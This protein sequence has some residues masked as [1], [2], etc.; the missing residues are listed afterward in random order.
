MKRL[1]PILVIFGLLMSSGV[2]TVFAQD[3]PV[4]N[5]G[6]AGSTIFLPVITQAGRDR[7]Q[8]VA[9]TG[10]QPTLEDTASIAVEK[11]VG[12]AARGLSQESLQPVSVIVTFDESVSAEQ[13]AGISGGQIIHRYDKILNGISMIVGEDKVPAV[14][15]MPGVTGVYL[16]ELNALNTDV[17]PAWIGA[18][19]TWAAL[20]GQE[21][22]GEGVIVG[23]IDSGIWPEHPSVS[24]PDPSGK[25]YAAPPAKWTGTGCDF[26]TDEFNPTDAPFTCNNKLIGAY[27]FTGTYAQ[28]IGLLPTEF[29]SARDSNGHGTHTTDHFRRQCRCRS[30]DLRSI[31]RHRLRYRTAR[32]CGRLQGLRR[33]RLLQLGHTWLPST[34]QWPTAS[35]SSTTR[36]AAVA[37]PSAMSSRW[38]SWTPMMPACWSCPRPA[39]L[40]PVRTRSL[41]GNRGPSPW[42][43]A[44]AIVTS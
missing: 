43:P 35:T 27:D 13:V 10:Q 44:P 34:R 14:A 38:A 11:G 36:S 12:A 39:T 17:S 19:T 9:P 30:L 2:S 40:G 15:S 22:A 33:R 42:A 37:I 29:A 28:V 25:P 3:D 5:N 24:D 18:P 8:A 41:T 4:P 7:E 32:P 6:Q 16:D 31:V 1:L 26:G 23:V 20:G 21:S